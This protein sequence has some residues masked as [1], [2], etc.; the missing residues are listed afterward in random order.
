MPPVKKETKM[1]Q[2]PFIVDIDADEYHEAARRGEFLSSHLLGDFRACPRLYKK[3]LLGEIEPVDTTAYQIGRALHTL[4]LEGRSKFDAEYLISSGPTNPKT[5]EAYGKTTKAYREWLAAQKRPVVSSEDFGWMLK[6]QQSVVLHPVANT[7]LERGRAEGTVRITLDG[8]PC[9]IRMD[10][11]NPS[12]EGKPVIVDLKT[13]ADFPFFEK[14]ARKYGYPEQLAFYREVFKEASAGVNAS[15]QDVPD[16]YI[17]A[18]EKREPFRC[19]VWKL[20]DELLEQAAAA[21]KM[22]MSLLKEC[23]RRG[24]WPT[25]YEELR[26]MGV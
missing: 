3:K 15:A 17:I 13:V 8:E 20:T 12:F 11:F 4:I 23:R 2:Y 25:G 7:L 24:E 10:W 14:D 9:Q 18:I 6:L 21:N 22:A 19:G 26:V 1:N 5:G 16:V